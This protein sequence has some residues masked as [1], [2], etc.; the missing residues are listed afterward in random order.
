M[1]ELRELFSFVRLVLERLGP[2]SILTLH[3]ASALSVPSVLLRRS[4]RPTSALAWLFAL[5]SLPGIGAAMWWAFGRTRMDR[6]LRSQERRRAGFAS[7]RAHFLQ[8]SFRQECPTFFSWLPDRALENHASVSN[9]NQVRLLT[10]GQTAFERIE[11][12]IAAAEHSVHLLFYNFEVDETGSRIVDLLIERARAGLTVRVLVDGFGS[13]GSIRQLRARFRSTNVEMGVFLPSRL[14]PLSAP[15]FNF[16]NHRKIIVIDEMIGFCG[17]MNIG[18]N[19]HHLW[20][21][22]MLEIRGSAVSCLSHVLLEDWYFSTRNLVD[23][24]PPPRDRAKPGV[25]MAVIASGPDTEPWIHDA[26]FTAITRAQRRVYI[27]TPY[28]IPPPSILAALRTAR[29][30]GV[31]VRVMIPSRNDVEFVKWAS[32]SF[33]SQLVHAGVRIFEYGE[34]MVHAKALLIDED[35]VSIG[36]ANVDNRSFRLNFEVSCFARD[37]ELATQLTGWMLDH[38]NASQ[39]ITREY[40]KEKGIVVRLLESAAHLTSPLL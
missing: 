1:D 19:Y 32:R 10:K 16:I 28:F 14:Y 6:K 40:L 25:E 8:S 29:G 30:R 39:E 20:H 34:V 4:G 2:F 11:E 23:D 38:M 18:D 24:P 13:S 31:D 36:T 35:I 17:G 15:R 26:Y 9:D 3:I 27:A 7:K 5:F 33:Y 37:P 12:T 22:L 21:D